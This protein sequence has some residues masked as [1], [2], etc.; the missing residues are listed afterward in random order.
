MPANLIAHQSIRKNKPKCSTLLYIV[1]WQDKP[2]MFYERLHE[3]LD[4]LVKFFHADEKGL[5]YEMLHCQSFLNVEERLQ[6][7]K[8][9]TTFLIDRYYRQ[10]LQVLFESSFIR[11]N[12]ISFIYNFSLLLCTLQVQD[13]LSNCLHSSFCFSRREILFMALFRSCQLN[14]IRKWY[15]NF[16]GPIEHRLLGIRCSNS[17]GVLEPRLSVRRGLERQ[18]C[19]TPGSKRL[20]RP[21]CHHRIAAAKSLRALRRAAHQRQE[22]NTESHVRRVF[23]I[24]SNQQD[25]HTGDPL[26]S[27]H[28][29][30]GP[31]L[32][33]RCEIDQFS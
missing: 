2:A 5:P 16:P 28:S 27:N 10:R 30:K 3:A 11:Y 31:F 19:D 22:E 7:H 25:V 1:L 13:I 33:E 12:Y 21:L 14:W 18:G 29:F 20:Q 6:Y 23:R 9:D 15:N 24:V 4:L 26:F 17:E 32:C 8:M